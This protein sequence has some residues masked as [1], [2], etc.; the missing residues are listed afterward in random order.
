[1]P[2]PVE[3]SEEG[4]YLRV[5]FPND[6]PL[7]DPEN[8]S[9]VY[10]TSDGNMMMAA[11]KKTALDTSEV[12]TRQQEYVKGNPLS[13]IVIFKGCVE[14]DGNSLQPFVK[15]T[16]IYSPFAVKTTGE[17]KID[18]FK[19]FNK[20]NYVLENH[21]VSGTAVIDGSKF[22]PGILEVNKLGDKQFSAS[23]DFIQQPAQHT[24]GFTLQ[25]ALPKSVDF[26]NRIVIV[27]PDI[28]ERS[29]EDPTVK[30]LDAIIKRA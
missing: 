12:F 30:N 22:R 27:M 10:Q 5:Q 7:P 14:V 2:F 11:N 13:N 23:I 21:L 26:D 8:S 16:N 19:S 17:F 3:K 4:C 18:L 25:N 1:M 6:M 20:V 28:M 15:I 29:S 9:V 24:I